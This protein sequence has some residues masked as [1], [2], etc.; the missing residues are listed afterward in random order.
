[1]FALLNPRLWILAAIVAALA[2]SHFTVY[3]KGKANV[4]MEWQAATAAANIE[5]FKASERRQRAVDDAAKSATARQAGIRADSAR[6]GDAVVRLR[7]A[8]AAKRNSDQSAAAANQRADT[9]GD[10]FIESVSA[11]R[12]LAQTCDRHVSDVR[13]LLDA[14]PR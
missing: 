13:L 3:R 6:A 12:E 11:Y 2:F 1:M 9:L 14:W 5:A 10:L 4:R 8:I 7:D